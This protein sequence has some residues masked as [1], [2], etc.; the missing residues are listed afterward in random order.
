MTPLDFG[1]EYTETIYGR[2]PVE[3]WN[4]YTNLIFLLLLV[5]FTRKTYGKYDRHKI[6]LFVLPVLAVGF[7]GGTLFHATRANRIFLILD[8]GPIFLLALGSAL[9]LWKR[10]TGSTFKAVALVLLLFGLNRLVRKAVDLPHGTA[11]SIGY[12]ILA[13]ILIVPALIDCLRNHRDLIKYILGALVLFS[14][15]ITFRQL[16]SHH[17]L[18]MG[19]HFLWHLFGG[20]SVYCMMEYMYRTGEPTGS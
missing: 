3:P 19:T 2:F 20:A 9:V 15:A 8:F 11:I 10:V 13:L 5:N 6:F 7:V 12:S 4:T 1:P 14:V 16:D 17:L 18:P